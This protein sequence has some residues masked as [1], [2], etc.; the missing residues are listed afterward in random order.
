MGLGRVWQPNH[1][2]W[3]WIKD[4]AKDIEIL[5]D[6]RHERIW[7]YQPI[8]V[9]TCLHLKT[10]LYGLWG[11]REFGLRPLSQPRHRPRHHHGQRHQAS[12]SVQYLR[13]ARGNSTRRRRTDYGGHQC[14]ARRRLFRQC[15]RQ[16]RAEV[17]AESGEGIRDSSS[18]CSG[19]GWFGGGHTR[20]V[21]TGTPP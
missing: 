1:L 4:T 15:Y 6:W 9:H 13:A 12:W 11:K 18:P 8:W 7:Q 20:C 10:Y 21:P 17:R 14:S 5:C 2:V 19:N 16:G 3:T